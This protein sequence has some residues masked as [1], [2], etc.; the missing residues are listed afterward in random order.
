MLIVE[1][2]SKQTKLARFG[3]FATRKANKSRPINAKLQIKLGNYLDEEVDLSNDE[4]I[5]P[6]LDNALDDKTKKQKLERLKKEEEQKVKRIHECILEES[7]GGLH[8]LIVQLI[9]TSAING[10]TGTEVDTVVRYGVLKDGTTENAIT[11]FITLA[12]EIADSIRSN[13]KGAHTLTTLSSK[14]S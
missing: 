9:G 5:G 6:Y 10:T 7:V 12:S 8:S 1:R 2:T 13:I 3:A 11:D 4:V 14:T